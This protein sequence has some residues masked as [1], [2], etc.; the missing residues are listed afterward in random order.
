MSAVGNVCI[1][2]KTL[3]IGCCFC[4]YLTAFLPFMINEYFY[5]GFSATAGEA[6]FFHICEG[7]VFISKLCAVFN[8]SYK[9]IF[10]IIVDS[11]SFLCFT[12]TEA[13]RFFRDEITASRRF[14]LTDNFY[15]FADALRG[16][17]NLRN[18]AVG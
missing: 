13:H 12:Y 11:G 8:I 9:N 10:S 3:P 15:W 1:Y 6:D 14:K 7:Q 16:N 17:F 5:N 18:T 4:L 2:R